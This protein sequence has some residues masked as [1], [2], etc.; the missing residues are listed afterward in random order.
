[1]EIVQIIC[2][3]RIVMPVD[4]QCIVNAVEMNDIFPYSLSYFGCN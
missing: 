1:M 2:D 3:H 4:L